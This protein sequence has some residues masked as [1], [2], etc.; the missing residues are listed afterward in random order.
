MKKNN[1]LALT[2]DLKSDPG[3]RD[4]YIKLHKDVWPEI[5]ASIIQAGILDMKIYSYENRLVMIIKV[6]ESFSFE[7]KA[8]LDAVNLKVQEWEALMWRYQKPVSGAKPNEKWVL[9]D[10]IFSIEESQSLIKS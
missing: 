10:E 8:A 1:C 5:K 3:C 7:R 4:E 6:D 2:L 9:M